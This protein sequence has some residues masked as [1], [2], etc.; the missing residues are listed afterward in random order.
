[1][2]MK[3]GSA[4]VRIEACRNVP[5]PSSEGSH[6]Q[7]SDDGGQQ[8]EC[9]MQGTQ[10]ERARSK[11]GKRRRRRGKTDRYL[12]GKLETIV[13]NERGS[14]SGWSRPKDAREVLNISQRPRTRSA[15]LLTEGSQPYQQSFSVSMTSNAFTVMG[16]GTLSSSQQDGAGN[17]IQAPQFVTN[18]TPKT[19][20]R[21][22][23]RM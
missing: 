17:K 4:R 8:R 6:K 10:K 20:Y 23:V 13:S 22:A 21:D 12:R 9:K 16:P 14:G 18:K 15:L 11:S 5:W 19:C 7:N 3:G 1:M 2:V